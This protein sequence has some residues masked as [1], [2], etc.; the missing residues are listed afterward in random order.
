MKNA[1]SI[2]RGHRF[3][4]AVIGCAVRWNYRFRL[5]LRDIE[6]LLFESGGIVRYETARRWCGRFGAGFA[7]RVKSARRT[8]GT[9]WHLDEVFLVRVKISGG[10]GTLSINKSTFFVKEHSIPDGGCSDTRLRELLRCWTFQRVLQLHQRL[11]GKEDSTP[12]GSISEST[13][14]RLEE[15]K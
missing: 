7:R 5:S 4:G 1:K 6:E 14:L 12:H 13:G 2:Y 15:V 10:A 3:P 8:P 11:G 9:T